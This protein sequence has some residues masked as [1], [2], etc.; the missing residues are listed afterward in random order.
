V[1]ARRHVAALVVRAA[2]QDETWLLE[3][4]RRC[5]RARGRDRVRGTFIVTPLSCPARREVALPG[6]GLRRR[7]DA[8]A[9]S[10]RCPM[11]VVAV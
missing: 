9:L 6:A 11:R 10:R 2:R 4:P 1:T 3:E 8:A 7:P 5:D